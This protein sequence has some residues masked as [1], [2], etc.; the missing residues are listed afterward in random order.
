MGKLWSSIA[1]EKICAYLRGGVSSL[2][3][4]QTVAHACEAEKVYVTADQ[5]FPA[6][7]VF[8]IM[9]DFDQ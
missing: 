7:V 8:V 3:S 1:I 5:R 6:M 9:D 2:T 4:C